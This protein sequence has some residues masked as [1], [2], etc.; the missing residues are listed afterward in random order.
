MSR[1]V[2]VLRVIPTLDPEM[3]G[4]QT[5][6]VNA[7]IAERRVDIEPTIIFAGDDRSRVST[8]PARARLE[9]AGVQALMFPRTRWLPSSTVSRWG[10]SRQMS[11][12]LLRNARHYDV[13]HVDYVWPWS[14]LIAAIAGSRA[15]RPVVMTAHESLTSFDIEANGRATNHKKQ[16]KLWLRALLMRYVDLLVMT[17][18]LERADS[19]RP[20]ECTI[21]VPHAVIADLPA[22]PP[23][24][25]P[26]PPLAVGYI[27]RLH[28]KKNLDVL[29]RAVA[30]S[31]NSIAVVV[32]GDGD[33]DY[34][35]QLQGLADEL[36]LNVEWR[37]H[38]DAAGRADLFAQSHVVAMPSAYE[39][40]GMAAAEAMAAGVPVIVSK[41]TG[42]APV[43]DEYDCGR[44]VEA[45]DVDELC[46]AL[47]DIAA[48]ASWRRR[49]RI[50]SLRAAVGTYSFD[51]YGERMA[52]IYAELVAG[53]TLRRHATVKC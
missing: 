13:I 41:T 9:S 52:A 34:R 49:A 12:W 1:S 21:V 5:T 44:L 37:G 18:E 48:D 19:V 31:E 35:A 51:S 50:N 6:I 10:I 38:V 27:G 30:T 14:T 11:V 42:V 26:L 36:S 4:P 53:A 17:S 25:P 22:Q 23:A 3:G 28:P 2:K 40:F 24:E 20:N 15:R 45:G 29:L 8:A 16:A 39:C 43:V 7:A 47:D 32:C 33:P 46:A